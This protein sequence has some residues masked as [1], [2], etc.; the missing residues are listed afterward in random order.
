MLERAPSALLRSFLTYHHDGKEF[1]TEEFTHVRDRQ[2]I[3]VIKIPARATFRQ[4]LVEEWAPKSSLVISP[5]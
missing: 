4:L 3:A 1:T 5:N 2:A